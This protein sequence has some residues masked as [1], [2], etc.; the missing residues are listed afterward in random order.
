MG[1]IREIFAKLLERALFHF[2]FHNDGDTQTDDINR[3]LE[4]LIDLTEK[5]VEYHCKDSAQYFWLIAKFAQ[6]DVSCC[7][8][9][10]R[11]NAF[12]NL[13][14][15]L[16]GVDP[17]HIGDIDEN[18]LLS[19]S[20]RWSTLQS[21]EFGGL[22]AAISYLILSCDT[23]P[24]RSHKMDTEACAENEAT[25]F[26]EPSHRAFTKSVERNNFLQMPQVVANV[27]YNCKGISWLF[28]R[29]SL[30]ACREV[31][32]SCEFGAKPIV[33]MLIQVAYGSSS[34]SH[35]LMDELM[36]QYNQVNSGELKNLSSLMLEILILKD[37]IQR[38]RLNYIIDQ[39][40]MEISRSGESCKVN[41]L[42][43]LVRSCHISDSKRAFL[44]IKCLVEA[45]KTSS[46]VEEKLLQDSE[47]W[48]WAVNWL[49][50]YELR[51]IES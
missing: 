30:C 4:N 18:S 43:A 45:A 46:V 29:E 48:Q 7:E 51:T 23:E 41:G 17:E 22:H 47:K 19:R 8:Q 27:L 5:D 49:K 35:V 44:S 25:P 11:L 37:G 9:L 26:E 12:R 20:R 28:V 33:D 13:T 32:G 39:C 50:E 42:L 16:L 15:F 24:H 1:D 6:M 14:K 2:A 21:R 36:K 34:F 40:E 3:I 38:P 10:F 31:S